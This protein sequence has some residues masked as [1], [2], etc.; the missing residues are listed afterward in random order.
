[1]RYDRVRAVEYAN[2]WAYRRNPAFYDF[3]ELGGDCT[4][5]AS[6]CLY[7]GS[8]VMNYTPIYGWYYINASNRTASWTGVE[9]LYNFLVNNKGAGPQ[10]EDTELKRIMAGD[11]VQL[12]FTGS[13]SFDH[14]PIVVDA[15][16]GTPETVLVAAHSVDSNCRPISSYNYSGIRPIHIYNVGT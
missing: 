4:N 16:D 8:G 7:A 5:F 10:G 2:K 13:D 1:M 9:Y 6:Q 12:R 11:I 15:G 3:S 14:T